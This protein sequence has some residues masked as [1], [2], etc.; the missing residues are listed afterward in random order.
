MGGANQQHTSHTKLKAPSTL[1]RTLGT[2]SPVCAVRG[3][4]ICAVTAG[5]GLCWGL[6][7]TG[8]GTPGANKPGRTPVCVMCL[9]VAG[10]RRLVGSS[11]G[12]LSGKL[13][14]SWQ[15]WHNSHV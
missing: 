5:R 8:L 15:P 3:D 2:A 1:V 11:A 7:A 14:C 12:L 13:Q 6:C 9:Y 10:S 4:C